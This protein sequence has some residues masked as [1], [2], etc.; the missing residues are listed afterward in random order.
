[1]L[2]GHYFCIAWHKNYEER[3][4]LQ[5]LYIETTTPASVNVCRLRLN[6]DESATVM[7]IDTVVMRRDCA[8]PPPNGDI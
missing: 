8:R 5:G 2:Q 4:P 1:M 6:S 7:R 3:C